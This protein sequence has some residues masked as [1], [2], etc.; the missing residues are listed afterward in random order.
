[1][2]IM[3]HTKNL[4][5]AAYRERGL[6]EGWAHSI[7]DASMR[8]L[9]ACGAIAEP[10]VR[11]VERDAEIYEARCAGCGTQEI[12]ERFGASRMSAFRAV[13]NH[14]ERLKA[15]LEAVKVVKR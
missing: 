3:R 14:K 6:D 9:F 15:A 1:M 12:R 5:I 7:A 8:V 4:L 11:I 2:V 13:R 10:R